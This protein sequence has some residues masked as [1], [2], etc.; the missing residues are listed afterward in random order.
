MKYFLVF[1]FVLG[2][3]QASQ[4]QIDLP[5]DIQG[6]LVTTDHRPVLSAC[7]VLQ[8]GCLRTSSDQQGRFTFQQVPP[9]QYVVQVYGPNLEPTREKVTVVGG[10]VMQLLIVVNHAVKPLLHNDPS[11][12]DADAIGFADSAGS[13]QVLSHNLSKNNGSNR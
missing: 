2:L 3:Y 10:V 6:R 13:G 7:V 9:G 8:Q 12:S 4:A 11:H 5:G 1:S